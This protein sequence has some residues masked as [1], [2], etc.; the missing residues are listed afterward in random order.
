MYAV[1][2]NHPAINEQRYFCK[3]PGAVRDIVWGVARAQGQP[4]TSEGGHDSEMIFEVGRL[5]S[6]ADIEYKGALKVLDFTVIAEPIGT[7]TEF[8]CEGG[9]EGEDA[10]LL[11]GPAICDGSCRPR[12]RFDR[13]ALADL[14]CA[15]DDADLDESGGCGACGLEAGQMCAACGR[16][17]CDR[18]DSCA[19]APEGATS[20]AE[21]PSAAP[22]CSSDHC[23][24]FLECGPDSKCCEV[25]C[26]CC[27]QV[28]ADDNCSLTPENSDG[29]RH[30]HEH[31]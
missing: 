3:S 28:S 18:H 17:N 15:L 30:C 1:T 14:A 5:L 8:D 20:A 13:E 25:T 9:H 11:G 4:I 21:A 22:Y 26:G 27:P 24:K 2:I 7:G 10:A 31:S 23:T 29:D 12:P 16:C 19:R 6:D